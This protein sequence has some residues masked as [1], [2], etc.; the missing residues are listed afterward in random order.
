[1]LAIFSWSY[2][3]LLSLHHQSVFLKRWQT[4]FHCS[5]SPRC[6]SLIFSNRNDNTSQISVAPR[7]NAHRKCFVRQ[8]PRASNLPLYLSAPCLHRPTIF[9]LL[10][11]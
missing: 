7:S 8:Y 11:L 9:T 5:H 6:S 1:M 3:L 10:D 4:S 2:V